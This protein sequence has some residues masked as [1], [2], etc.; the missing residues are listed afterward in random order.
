MPVSCGRKIQWF[1]DTFELYIDVKLQKILLTKEQVQKYGLP[2]APDSKNKVEIDALEV[3]YPDE[4]RKI[5]TESL[6]QYID[7]KATNKIREQNTKIQNAIYEAILEQK[8]SINLLEKL[9]L[10]EVKDLCQNYE[11]PKSKPKTLD[12]V[13]YIYDSDLDY[14][15]QVKKFKDYLGK[16][17]D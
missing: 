3:Y 9:D 7:L 12:G 6:D 14:I 4:T 17:N 11:L 15:S 8:D 5:V 2:S 16:R 10:R 13:E 1:L